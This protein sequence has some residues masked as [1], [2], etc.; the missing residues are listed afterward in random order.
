MKNLAIVCLLAF[1]VLLAG[2][3]GPQEQT[4]ETGSVS[5]GDAIQQGLPDEN[6]VLGNATS[7]FITPE[8][9]VEIGE[10]V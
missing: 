3:V 2:C 8:S 5:G 10:M 9:E 7:L 6:S 1:S 4:Q